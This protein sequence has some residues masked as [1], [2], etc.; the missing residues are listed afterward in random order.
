MQN[1]Q[2]RETSN[3][4]DTRQRKNQRKTNPNTMWLD[5]TIHK[6]TQI[7]LIRQLEVETNRKSFVC[8]NHNT[9]PK[10]KRNI[11]GEHKTL[12]R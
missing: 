4:G 11:T 6:P 8:G 7:T 3:A 10:M 12:K 9:E 1:G 5:T 2:S